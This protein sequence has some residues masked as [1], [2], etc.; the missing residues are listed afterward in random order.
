MLWSIHCLDGDDVTEKRAAL[1]ADHSAHL[2]TAEPAPLVYGPLLDDAGEHGV[3]S[4]F[5]IDAPDRAAA[6]HWVEADPFHQGGV[7]QTVQVHAFRQSP[8]APVQIPVAAAA[9]SSS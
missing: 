4:F 3:G 8:N 9:T 5:L 2:R 7:W 6:E 1:A